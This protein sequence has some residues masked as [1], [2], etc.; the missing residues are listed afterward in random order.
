MCVHGILKVCFIFRC[1]FLAVEVCVPMYLLEIHEYGT[2][3]TN[4]VAVL[5]NLYSINLVNLTLK[6]GGIYK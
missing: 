4:D 6:P 5:L 1:S 2:Y 3:M